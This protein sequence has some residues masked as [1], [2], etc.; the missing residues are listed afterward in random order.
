MSGQKDARLDVSCLMRRSDIAQG[1]SFAKRK[2]PR[3]A[4]N[5]ENSAEIF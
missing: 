5:I 1:L 3:R 2:I 4:I